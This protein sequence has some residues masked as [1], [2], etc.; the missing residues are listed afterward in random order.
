MIS[1]A[2]PGGRADKGVGLGP[3]ACWDCGFESRRAHGCLSLVSVVLSGAGLCAGLITRPDESYRVWCVCD[4]E[5]LDNEET[6]AH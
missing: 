1:R 4:R 3:L 2:D 6:L 5:S